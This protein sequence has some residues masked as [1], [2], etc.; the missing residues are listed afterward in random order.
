M[1]QA[2]VLQPA[3]LGDRSRRRVRR[4]QPDVTSLWISLR[5]VQ[6]A[7]QWL[8]A[9]LFSFWHFLSQVDPVNSRNACLSLCPQTEPI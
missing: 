9:G 1:T 2:R 3:S 5:R 7:V 6:M 8:K 4:M